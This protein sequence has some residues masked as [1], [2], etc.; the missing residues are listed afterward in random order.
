MSSARAR[1][2]LGWTPS[3]SSTDALL[4]L[5]DGIRHGIGGPSPVLRS[6]GSALS[7]LGTAVRVA[8]QGGAGNQDK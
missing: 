1:S 4:D 6:A 3:W 7:R 8:A 5:L 2:V